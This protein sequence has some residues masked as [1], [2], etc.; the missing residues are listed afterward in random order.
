MNVVIQHDIVNNDHHLNDGKRYTT[1]HF[2]RLWRIK[3]CSI[4]HDDYVHQRMQYK[5]LAL[6]FFAVGQF[7]I[8]KKPDQPKLT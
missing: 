7:V 6:G 1:T 5:L 2:A 8:E 4:Q 3:R